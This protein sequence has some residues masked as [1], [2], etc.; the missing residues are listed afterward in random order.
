MAGVKD[1][2]LAEAKRI[3]RDICGRGGHFIQKWTCAG[4]GERAGMDRPDAIYTE[5]N[6]TEKADG[7]NCGTVIDLRIAGCG[8]TAILGHLTPTQFQALFPKADTPLTQKEQT[9]GG[10]A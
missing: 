3:A 9:G 2:G 6:H 10:G 4:C 1:V 5:G 8:I 7:S